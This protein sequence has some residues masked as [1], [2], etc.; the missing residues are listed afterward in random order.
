MRRAA[1]NHE[2]STEMGKT[3][4]SLRE[5]NREKEVVSGVC[6]GIRVLKPAKT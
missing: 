5:H 1:C 2:A 4:G 3:L 6:P